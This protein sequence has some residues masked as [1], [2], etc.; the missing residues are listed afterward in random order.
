MFERGKLCG[1]MENCPSECPGEYSGKLAGRVMF[2]E[3]S[4][5]GEYLG[6]YPHPT[7]NYKSLRVAV[8]IS[9]TLVN[10]PTHT[11]TD[12]F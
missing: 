12:S 3:F 8:M 10:T 2:G 9:A 4:G 11:H 6:E 5:A 1:D 7:H